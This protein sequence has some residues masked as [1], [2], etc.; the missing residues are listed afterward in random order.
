MRIPFTA[1]ALVLSSLAL[2]AVERTGGV[3][4]GASMLKLEGVSGS[5]V[6]EP[7]DAEEVEVGW[8][9]TAET[10][11]QL[12]MVSVE[13]RE[14]DGILSVWVDFAGDDV[15]LDGHGVD[16]RLRV[17][18][19]WEGRL[20][21]QQVSGD[22]TCTEGGRFDLVAQCV[23]GDLE[24]FGVT[25]E[26]HLKTVSGGLFFADLPGLRE[27]QVVSG[28][29]QGSA[30]R[31]E[32]SLEI[33]CVSGTID[34]AIPDELPGRVD[35]SA[36][37]GDIEIGEGLSGFTLEEGLTGFSAARGSGEPVLSISSLSGEVALSAL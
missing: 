4:T 26:V 7:A 36:M 18:A 14:D 11:D 10:A 9:V 30:E 13:T 27:A 2:A 28:T 33:D 20:D 12:E 23:S 15:S 37:S 17:P 3:V 29:M 22:I 6:V 19:D 32:N 5:I 31:L 24:V 1:A 34:L 21:L 8:T 35:V 16:F 25:G